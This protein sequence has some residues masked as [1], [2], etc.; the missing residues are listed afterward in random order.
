MTPST[1]VPE[2]RPGYLTSEFWLGVIA[3]VLV[4]YEAI[5]P[6]FHVTPSQ[7]TKLTLAAG[8]LSLVATAFYT[9][10]RKGV[11]AA[12][13]T[14]VATVAAAE[15]AATGYQAT[16]LSEPIAG[17]V[18]HLKLARLDVPHGLPTSPYEAIPQAEKKTVKSAPQ[19]SAR[20]VR[21]TDAKPKTKTKG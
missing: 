5:N 9:V 4:W 1:P 3:Q 21:L 10:S 18:G 15:I 20:G 13:Q 2:P 14:A 17:A 7:Q 19:R 8:A 12:H 6:S 11:K 16:A